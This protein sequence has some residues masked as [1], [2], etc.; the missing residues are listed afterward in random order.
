MWNGEAEPD[1]YCIHTSPLTPPQKARGEPVNDGGGKWS[2]L[3][4]GSS[5][6]PK[7]GLIP[8]A[9]QIKQGMLA[10]NGQLNAPLSNP[11]RTW[12]SDTSGRDRPA[13]VAGDTCRRHRS[14]GGGRALFT[15]A[16]SHAQRDSFGYRRQE[17]SLV[18]T[19]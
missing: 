15:E 9:P 12:V 6:F 5:I 2:R 17:K 13:T 1:C 8:A 3:A 7:S 14:V 4:I 16:S 11:Q 10:S 19:L 18:P